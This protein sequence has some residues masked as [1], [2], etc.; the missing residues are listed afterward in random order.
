MCRLKTRA[1]KDKEVRASSPPPTTPLEL[2]EVQPSEQ[3]PPLSSRSQPLPSSAPDMTRPGSLPILPA[4]PPLPSCRVAQLCFPMA[5]P[6]SSHGNPQC[7]SQRLCS[8]WVPT[9]SLHMSKS[10]V[11]MSL[12]SGVMIS[13]RPS[14][15]H[16]SGCAAALLWAPERQESR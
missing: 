16:Y 9:S 15:T 12:P 13:Q 5:V 6:L 7:F 2:P 10:C 8:L 11:G 14:H 3:G 4:N 1:C